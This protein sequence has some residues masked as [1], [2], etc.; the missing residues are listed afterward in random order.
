MRSFLSLLLGRIDLGVN[1][2]LL[3]LLLVEASICGAVSTADYVDLMSSNKL[4]PVV[5]ILKSVGDR[6]AMRR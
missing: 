3:V 2:A 1:F 5:V 4:Q 6:V